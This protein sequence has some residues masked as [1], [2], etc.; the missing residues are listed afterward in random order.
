MNDK[1]KGSTENKHQNRCPRVEVWNTSFRVST[2]L[3]EITYTLPPQDK[4]AQ[5][6]VDDG[7]HDRIQWAVRM[8]WNQYD[9]LSKHHIGWGEDEADRFS[10]A[11]QYLSLADILSYKLLNLPRGHSLVSKYGQKYLKELRINVLH[12]AVYFYGRTQEGRFHETI[13]NCCLEAIELGNEDHLLY[14]Y[15]GSGWSYKKKYR[16]SIEL[17]D[18]ALITNPNDFSC[19]IRLSLDYFYLKR[20]D[21]ALRYSKKAEENAQK[22]IELNSVVSLCLMIMD[23]PRAITV[24]DRI[25]EQL[26]KGDHFEDLRLSYQIKRHTTIYYAFSQYLA[27]GDT[28]KTVEYYALYCVDNTNKEMVD[29]LNNV[30]RLKEVLQAG[31]GASQSEAEDLSKSYYRLMTENA[32]HTRLKQHLD[33]YL[34]KLDESNKQKKQVEKFLKK[35]FFVF[36]TTNCIDLFFQM[37]EKE[38]DL[39]IVIDEYGLVFG[40]VSK[41]DLLEK[42]VGRKRV[43]K[44]EEKLYVRCASDVI[45]ADAKMDLFEFETVFNIL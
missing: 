22:F 19:Y 3:E 31:S 30:D 33:T 16:K 14:Y 42:M 24:Y 10:S 35:P 40:K 13:F 6:P 8:V 17:L 1:L 23:W 18:K 45:I 5:Q 44:H 15:A 25:L 32:S 28:S 39:A 12:S 43:E 36:E 27:V 29:V 26:Q 11:L 38:I 20:N 37:K 9:I 4:I 7:T 2:Y 21:V 41:K 34:Q